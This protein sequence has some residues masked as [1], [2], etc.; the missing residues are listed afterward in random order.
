MFPVARQLGLVT[1]EL[2]DIE[3]LLPRLQQEA[4]AQDAIIVMPAMITGW[5]YAA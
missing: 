2:A 3:A 1:G 5:A 4:A